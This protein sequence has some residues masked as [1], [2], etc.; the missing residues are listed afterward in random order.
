MK[1]RAIT[2]SLVR[3]LLVPR[4]RDSHKGT[5][6]HVAVVAGSRSM[7]GAARLCAA[8]ALRAGAGLVTAAVPASV[9][10]LVAVASTPEIMTL[11]LPETKEGSVSPRAAAVLSGLYRDK[12]IT[13]AVIGPGLG[14][15]SQINRFVTDALR[16]S[17]VPLIIDADALNALSSA[18]PAGIKAIGTVRT[19]SIVTPHPGE[20]GR[21]CG[22]P[23]DEIQKGREKA[24]SVFAGTY[25]TVCVLKGR[26]TVVADGNSVYLNT[27]GNPGMAT[28]GA[29]DVLAGIIAALIPQVKGPRLLNAALAGVYIH[30][31]A[32]DIAARDM[33]EIS[34][35]AGDIITALPRAF[36]RILKG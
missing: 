7:S 2:L 32:G 9:L 21:L 12:N 30:G 5:Y 17:G 19:G 25:R 35:I 24:A 6:G 15:G 4:A 28:G 10:Q 16:S 3:S 11:G 22:I 14:S 34:L 36:E 8:A 23:A 1:T 27:T 33:T 29:G 13:A 20:M 31:L 18:G 26:G